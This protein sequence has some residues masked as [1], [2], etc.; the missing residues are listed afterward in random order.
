MKSGILFFIM[1]VV[2]VYISRAQTTIKMENSGGV[3]RIPCIVNGLGLKFIFD[4][5]ASDVSISMTEAVFMLKNGYLSKGDFLGLEYYQIANGEIQEGTKVNLKY[6]EIGGQKIYNIRASIIHSSNAPLLLG[7]SALR[8]F[9]NFYID[10]STN[11]L[12]LGTTVKDKEISKQVESNILKPVLCNDVEG[13]QYEILNIGGQKWLGRNLDISTFRNG[14]RIVEAKTIEEWESAKLNKVA[15]WC[16]YN[17]DSTNELKYGKL[18]NWY[19]INDFRQLAPVG[20]KIASDEDWQKLIDYLGGIEFAGNILKSDSNWHTNDGTNN[21]H[22]SAVPSGNR[23]YNGGTFDNK[24]YACFWWTTS[25]SLSS[26]SKAWKYG[27]LDNSSI[28]RELSDKN[29]GYSVRCI[30]D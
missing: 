14:D 3:Y 2:A 26:D 8:R 20:Y 13:H 1:T 21:F 18:Y 28:I 24:G 9:G 29:F 12:S 15:A 19:A 17:N 6:L 7:Q 25:P 30:K 23:S 22:F 16:Y 5:G 11:K 10:Y 4:T 27:I